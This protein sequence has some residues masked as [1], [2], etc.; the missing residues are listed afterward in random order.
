VR[1]ARPARPVRRRPSPVALL[2]RLVPGHSRPARSCPVPPCPPVGTTPG[3][4][5]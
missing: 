2:R 3:A 1:A 4:P 5:A